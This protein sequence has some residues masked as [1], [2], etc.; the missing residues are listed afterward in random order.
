[1]K[2]WT[3]LKL[4]VKNVFTCVHL[5]DKCAAEEFVMK[6][7]EDNDTET[8]NCW[9]NCKCGEERIPKTMTFSKAYLDELR[10]MGLL[11]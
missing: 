3:A 5:V 10:S 2:N 4:L 1:M 11:R 9:C 7:S 6:V 8:W